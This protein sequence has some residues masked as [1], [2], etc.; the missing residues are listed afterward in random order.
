LAAFGASFSVAPATYTVT[1]LN[2]GNGAG[3]AS[4]PSAQAGTPITLTAVPKSG[5]QLKE[6]QAVSGGAS[7]S[8]NSFVMPVSNVIITAVFE[9]VP[10]PR[11]AITLDPNGGKLYL[12]SA[13]TGLDGRLAYLPTPTRSGS[14]RFD[15]W[16]TAKADGAQVTVDTVFEADA[17]I[18]ARWTSTASAGSGNS[19][20]GSGG[21]SASVSTPS[22]T[23]TPTPADKPIT[24]NQAVRIGTSTIITPKG[25]PPVLN[26]D[27]GTTL[28]GGGT[29]SLPNGGAIDVPPG[30]AISGDGKT[31]T[32]P[33][34]WESAK[35]A[36]PS[37]RIETVEPGYEI[38]L[39]N[40][41]TP[42]ASLNFPFSDISPSAWYYEDVV[43]V[44]IHDLFSGTG[45][46][47]FSPGAPTTRGMVA[48]VLHRLEGEPESN[49]NASP[50]GDVDAGDYY[51]KPIA[52]AKA[53]GI[54]FGTGSN[55]FAP[56]T[57][58]TRQD[59]IL[60]LSRYASFTDVKLPATRD[61]TSFKDFASAAG[62]AKDAIEAF[63]KAG[64]ISGKGEGIFDPEGM[65][66]RA[67]FSAI[68]RRFIE[69]AKR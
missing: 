1:V 7:I 24:A 22:P 59:S 54:V 9:E 13:L 55:L 2:D 44:Y 56:D 64:I 37:G 50:F 57:P 51:A 68:L 52:W 21:Q 10:A 20:G 4:P 42:L 33:R 36:Y 67:E 46:T 23:R 28:P 3:G 27:G 69:A 39:D 16:F 14:Y 63:C 38:S 25:K 66:T 30:A 34:G 43:Y 60:T 35:I 62:Y 49:E 58:I 12:A 8:G 18:Y 29:V 47:T 40:P 11:R 19:G 15:G 26:P 45:N 61:W 31:V 5:Y 48:A 41:E 53:K 17:T 6:W 65:T 32:I